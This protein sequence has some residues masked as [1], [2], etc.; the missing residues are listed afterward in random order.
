MSAAVSS[1]CMRAAGKRLF[2]GNADSE[3]YNMKI[4]YPTFHAE[5]WMYVLAAVVIVIFSILLY[6]VKEPI[7]F[8]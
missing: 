3:I 8:L 6:T 1:A 2:F 7:K 4:R 5:Y